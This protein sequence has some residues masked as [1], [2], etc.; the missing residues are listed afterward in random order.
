MKEWY[1]V[2]ELFIYSG[3]S[4]EVGDTETKY[5]KEKKEEIYEERTVFIF[6][7]LSLFSF[8]R[9]MKSPLHV[10]VCVLLC[11][12]ISICQ[13]IDCTVVLSVVPYR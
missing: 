8:F 9:L 4:N 12:P 11:V 2:A 7:F 13:T 5:E 3:H 6:L 10:P 1:Y